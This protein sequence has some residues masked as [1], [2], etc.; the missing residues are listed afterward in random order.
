M[1]SI[2]LLCLSGL[3]FSVFC[4][5]SKP[6]ALREAISKG[7]LQVSAKGLGGHEGQ[8][9]EMVITSMHKKAMQVSIEAGM[10]LF[11]ND[12]S[13]QS[14]MV[15]QQRLV[16]LEPQAVRKI[17]LF[18]FCIEQHDGGPSSDEMFALGPM[19]DGNLLEVVQFINNKKFQ[20]SA[21]QHAIWCITDSA[22]LSGIY[23]DTNP[24]LAKELR[25]FVAKLTGRIPPWYQTEHKIQPGV[26]ET[27]N[28][29]KIHADFQYK[30]TTDGIVTFGI[31]NEQG[32]TVQTILANHA[33]KAGLHIMKIRFEAHNL[34]K[35][36]YYARVMNQGV[37]VE[38]RVFEL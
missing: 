15:S 34:P 38:E 17:K 7:L 2:V 9:I 3:S 37:L 20:T 29:V 12:T 19:A 31:Y 27:F 33:E 18:A 10:K 35:G 6:V 4:A 36:K 8:C 32:D 24:A 30:L 1:R 25:M 22:S 16:T 14:M 28:P 26:E 21:A 13:I 5:E 11:P 23:D